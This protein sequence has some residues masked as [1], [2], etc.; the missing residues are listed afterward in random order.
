MAHR[1][2]FAAWQEAKQV[3]REELVDEYLKYLAQT[4]VRVRH[5]T[6][7]ADLVARHITTVEG[8]PCN[9]STL[10]RN[11]RYKAKILTHQARL[12]SGSQSLNPRC[13]KDPIA[14]ALLTSTFLETGNLKR[15]VERLNIY[16]GTL[17]GQL[18]H[19]NQESTPVRRIVK[20]DDAAEKFADGASDFEFKFIRTCQSL[21]ALL[22]DMNTI[23]V[24]DIESAQILDR[25]KRRNN[26]V[27]STELAGPFI[28]WL[29]A[30]TKRSI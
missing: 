24:V 2:S 23:L 13:V 5:A 4:R 30:S 8:T 19:Y 9:K 12:E 3:R 14:Q 1:N 17:E 20:D 21:R 28:E 16:I 25:S 11:V 26:V 18:E 6:D 15:E 29:V 10:M 22:N 27:V 7:L